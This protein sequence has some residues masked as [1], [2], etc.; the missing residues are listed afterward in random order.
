[1]PR[2]QHRPF[3]FN[4]WWWV[5]RLVVGQF[6]AVA[7]IPQGGVSATMDRRAV[8]HIA[9]VGH[10][11][12][13]GIRTSFRVAYQSGIVWFLNAARRDG[14]LMAA[15]C[16][17][18]L[19]GGDFRGKAVLRPSESLRGGNYFRRPLH[20][21]FIGAFRRRHIVSVRKKRTPQLPHGGTLEHRGNDC[22]R[23]ADRKSGSP[24]YG[25][26]TALR[27]PLLPVEGDDGVAYVQCDALP[28][29]LRFVL[30]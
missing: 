26:R 17:S 6:D 28:G 27:S 12:R 22:H 10:T 25:L 23:N 4:G 16:T 13:P 8:G 1:L 29:S 14:S 9:P 19:P 3:A 20:P 2:S 30:H 5:K 15:S 24:H 7:A 11:T 18:F 21:T